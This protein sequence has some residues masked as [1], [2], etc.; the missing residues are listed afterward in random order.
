[1]LH[2]WYQ[3]RV[4]T[5]TLHDGF[6]FVETTPLKDVLTVLS[7][8]DQ[9]PPLI[10]VLNEQDHFLGCVS[11]TSLLS[12]SLSSSHETR[13]KHLPWAVDC[14]AIAIDAPI[15][16]AME[17]FATRRHEVLPVCRTGRFVGFLS[18]KTILANIMKFPLRETSDL[19][20]E[21]NQFVSYVAHDLGNPLTIILLSTGLL[22]HGPDKDPKRESQLKMIQRAARQALRISDDL[23]QSER[24]VKLG[25]I[26]SKNVRLSALMEEVFGEN[27]E[28]VQFK[29]ARLIIEHC[30]ESIVSLDPLLIKRCLLNLIDN[31]CKFSPKNGD[32][33]LSAT[34]TTSERPTLEF[35]VRDQGKGFGPEQLD[36]IFEPFVHSCKPLAGY[37]LGL[38][39]V[40]RFVEFHGGTVRAVNCLEGGAKFVLSIPCSND[41]SLV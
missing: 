11:L 39:I 40:R 34:R 36:Q 33:F 13:L 26:F 22:L 1:M 15:L 24:Y 31:A 37:G 2:H 9:T 14:D 10:A 30:D 3:K 23:L 18:A 21:I 6:A 35:S 29:G 27:E 12:S 8:S 41:P 20:S 28:F 4:E 5:I 32:I 38:V 7:S 25:R 16:D 19:N 17:Q